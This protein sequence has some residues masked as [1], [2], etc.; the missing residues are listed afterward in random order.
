MSMSNRDRRRWKIVFWLS[1]GFLLPSAYFGYRVGEDPLRGIA[2]GLA[3]SVFIAT[4]ILLYE[5][6]GRRLAI[7]RRLQR[8]PIAIYFA[9]RVVLYVIIIVAGLMAAR[10][11]VSGHANFDE[12][13]GDGGFPFSVAM[14]V[15]ANVVFTMG[16][17]L[18][19]RMV[20]RL[21]TG[22]YVRPRRELR[23]FLLIDMKN[24]TGVAE[25]LG[26]V[27]FH[28]LLN[29]FFRDVAEAAL[30][31]SAEIHKYVGDEVILTWPAER[32]T[33]DDDVLG[34]PFVVHDFIAAS[35]AQYRRR[36]GVVPEFRAAMHCGEIVAGQIGDV[37]AEIAYV[38]DTL[39]VAAR[40]LEA[41]KEVGRDVLV[42]SDLLAKTT[43]P[44]GIVAEALPM[45]TVRGRAAP[46][47]IA[48]LSRA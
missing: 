4:P 39:N 23:A 6:K 44:S 12:I 3:S 2:T 1:A 47:G 33:L 13:F 10:L 15:V 24:S 46:L 41:A 14:A 27:H 30:E 32:A 28:E 36:F 29:D 22:R 25:R 42:S 11:V 7:V 45:L 31:C 43:L 38:G 5:V 16:S 20:G 40:L 19:F 26:A 18:G 35:G 37:R 34:C 21:A 48:A 9:I 17:L 8:M